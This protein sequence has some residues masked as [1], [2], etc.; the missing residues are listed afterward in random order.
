MV[1]F[2][3]TGL[4]FLCIVAFTDAIGDSRLSNVFHGFW[5]WFYEHEQTL[6]L[7]ALILIAV[8]V[9]GCLLSWACTLLH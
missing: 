9:F 7:I 4:T 6:F 8:G 3:I 5:G 2:L 1:A